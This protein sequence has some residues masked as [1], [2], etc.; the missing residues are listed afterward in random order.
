MNGFPRTFCIVDTETTGMRPPY[1]RV[2]DLGIIRVEDGKEV[3]R[4][5]TLLNP[6]ISIPASITRITS[7]R[8]ED[9]QDA[10]SFED[11][12]LQ[13][14][15]LFAGAVFVA[16][17]APFDFAFIR[18]EFERLGMPFSPPAL[19]TVKLSR[20]LAPTAKRHSLDAVIERYG[21]PVR[22]RHRAMP[23][24]EAVWDFIQAL[25]SSHEADE[26]AR[27]AAYAQG[28]VG[29]SRAAKDSFTELPSESGVYFFYGPDQE[30]LY[31]GKS[32]HVR[33][34][35]RSHFH[36]TRDRKELRLQEETAMVSSIATSGELSALILESALIKQ[37]QPLYN[38]ALRKRATLAIARQGENPLGYPTLAVSRTGDLSPDVRILGVFR[39]TTQAKQA[40][41]TIAKEHRLCAKLLDIESGEGACFA[42]QLDA[43]DGACVGAADLET[44][45]NRFDTAFEKR[46]MRAWPYR[47]VVRIDERQS[48]DSGTVFFIDDWVLRGAYRYEG[49]AFEP[50]IEDDTVGGFDYDTYKILV[51]YLLVPKN[52]RN[53][54]V[55][56]RPEFERWHAQKDDSADGS[57]ERIIA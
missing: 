43:C 14:E 56:T 37:Q 51:R 36:S 53:I 25:P 7:L 31:I 45:R 13:V 35:A 19:C 46:R 8:S 27:A 50:L 4:F 9:L 30:L 39:T 41:R 40:L 24:A 55:L 1:S 32:K 34:R 44:Y 29:K 38:R 23:D 10:P 15:E 26:I 20:S 52:R 42:R 33:T 5:D 47:G 3:E 21:L 12:A 17:N 18:N 48:T 2:I 22:E 54:S 11:V 28:D 57:I 49:D 6:G 16:H